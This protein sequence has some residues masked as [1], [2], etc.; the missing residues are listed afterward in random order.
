M[1]CLK[2]TGAKQIP[3]LGTLAKPGRGLK[4]ARGE[5]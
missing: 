4:E 2:V 5:G 3:A 1:R